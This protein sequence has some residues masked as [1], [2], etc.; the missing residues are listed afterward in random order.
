MTSNKPI[1]QGDTYHCGLYAL[2]NAWKLKGL[3]Q[4]HLLEQNHYQIFESVLSRPLGTYE[5]VTPQLM[6]RVIE[7]INDKKNSP[8]GDQLTISPL[9]PTQ[10]KDIES[11]MR[12]VR[13]ALKAGDVILTGI[14]EKD[15]DLHWTLIRQT[16]PLSLFDSSGRD[17][18]YPIGSYNITT[19]PVYPFALLFYPEYSYRL[20]FT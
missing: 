2:A 4:L 19:C 16:D 8:F 13:F 9:F 11:F 17:Q 12:S 14:K 20:S 6:D 15:V 7:H 5:S 1:P 10:P 3:D 18:P